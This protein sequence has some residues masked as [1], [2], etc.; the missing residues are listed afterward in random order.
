MP[1]PAARACAPLLHDPDHRSTTRI[2]V[3]VTN[4]AQRWAIPAT[5]RCRFNCS[6]AAAPAGSLWLSSATGGLI[7]DQ[8][9]RFCAGLRARLMRLATGP[10]T[11]PVAPPPPP[12]CRRP[13]GSSAMKPPPGPA[14]P[15]ACTSARVDAPAAG[16]RRLCSASDG[17]DRKR[18]RLTNPQ[19]AAAQ[20]AG[21][22]VARVLLVDQDPPAEWGRRASE[23]ISDRALCPPRSLAHQ[24][25]AL[26]P[27]AAR[28]KLHPIQGRRRIRP[29]STGS[30]PQ[31]AD[32]ALQ[33]PGTARPQP[34]ET[35]CPPG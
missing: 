12:A 35:P 32:P 9:L 1:C 4:R 2:G 8:Q 27:F 30:R 31:S 19:A 20:L 25:P 11:Q 6:I 17:I 26:W 21:G 7:E 3:G 10:P 33:L 24:W 28:L 34:P 18:V 22:S 16:R 14:P 29:R 5:V 23:Q 13:C 15:T